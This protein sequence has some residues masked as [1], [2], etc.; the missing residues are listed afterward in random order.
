MCRRFHFHYVLAVTSMPCT[1]GPTI[2]FAQKL[3]RKIQFTKCNT[4]LSPGIVWC[5]QHESDSDNEMETETL[6][7]GNVG[8]APK[9]VKLSAQLQHS[10]STVLSLA[11]AY[12]KEFAADDR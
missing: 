10:D 12:V 11:S 6:A 3:K 4:L 1:R 2:K 8:E 5:M 9:T 7:D